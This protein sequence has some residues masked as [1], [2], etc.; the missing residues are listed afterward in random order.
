MGRCDTLSLPDALSARLFN[1]RWPLLVGLGG[2]EDQRITDITTD[3][4]P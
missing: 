2:G 4:F 1:V 3:S